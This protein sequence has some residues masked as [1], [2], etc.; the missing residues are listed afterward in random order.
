[1]VTSVLDEKTFFMICSSRFQTPLVKFGGHFI[2][3]ASCFVALGF[4]YDCRSPAL[5]W[6]V[7]DTEPVL[8]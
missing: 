3:H 2:K 8:Q 6:V 5:P 1:M 7:Q 4:L